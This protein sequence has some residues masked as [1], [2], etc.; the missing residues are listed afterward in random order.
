MEI[1][2]HM[3]V[4]KGMALNACTV[5][6]NC[7]QEHDFSLLYTAPGVVDWGSLFQSWMLSTIDSLRFSAK[8]LA[9]YIR[10]NLTEDQ[11]FLLDLADDEICTLLQMLKDASISKS[12]VGS[13]FGSR[14]SA[15]ELLVICNN[16][17]LSEVNF[18]RIIHSSRNDVLNSIISLLTNGGDAEKRYIFRLL[19]KLLN[20]ADFREKANCSGMD[21]V[22]CNVLEKECDPSLSFLCQC[23]LIS[24][25]QEDHSSDFGH[26]KVHY[27][28]ISSANVATFLGEFLVGLT[29]GLAPIIERSRGRLLNISVKRYPKIDQLLKGV[30][31][32]YDFW[33]SCSPFVQHQLLEVICQQSQVIGILHNF[34]MEIYSGNLHV[35]MF[36]VVRNS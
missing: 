25:R 13:G 16:L 7:A 26:R 11:H 29:D 36:Q 6:S 9:G 3:Q 27:D 4:L 2:L 30:T 12:F 32:V 24:L 19:L 20:C 15:T 23:A 17:I 5:L 21:E 34:I 14:Y 31:E 35:C 22:L 28:S 18:T 33:N 1:L 8:V 10:R